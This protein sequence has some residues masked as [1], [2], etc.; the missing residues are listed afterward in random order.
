VLLS[1]GN[2]IFGSTEGTADNDA[3]HR[4]LLY[5]FVERDNAISSSIKMRMN[6]RAVKVNSAGKDRSGALLL[7]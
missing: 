5:Y 1:C 3:V 7:K 2:S 4:V 6:P